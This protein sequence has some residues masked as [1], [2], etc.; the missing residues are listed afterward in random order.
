[1]NSLLYEIMRL[2]NFKR[3]TLKLRHS[4]AYLNHLTTNLSLLNAN[5]QSLT[6]FAQCYAC[7]HRFLPSIIGTALSWQRHPLLALL[8]IRYSFYFDLTTAYFSLSAIWCEW[9]QL[10]SSNKR[11]KSCCWCCSASLLCN[12]NSHRLYICKPLPI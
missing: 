5:A 11:R 1:M 2:S 4:S 6:P 8:S 7:K 10:L 9:R 3:V 12:F